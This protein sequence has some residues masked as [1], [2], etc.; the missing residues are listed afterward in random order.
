MNDLE[1]VKRRYELLKMAREL[2]NGE[3][4]TKRSEDHN[5]WVMASDEEWKNTRMRLPYPPFVPYP[6]EDDVLNSATKL[7]NFMY[8][9][10]HKE[11][12]TEKPQPK[13][14]EEVKNQQIETIKPV[15]ETTPVYADDP[16]EYYEEE[17]IV[18]AKHENKPVEK[19]RAIEKDQTA[20]V[21]SLLPGWV[22]RTK[23]PR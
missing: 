3:Y 2:L 20:E 12:H 16:E 5:K 7:Y 21:K 17:T 8:A 18:E 4:A 15:V 11:T 9:D 22:R 19:T 6:T 10:S 1:D 23:N 13:F 14:E